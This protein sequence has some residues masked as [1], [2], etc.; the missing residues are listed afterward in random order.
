MSN[1]VEFL[2]ASD[3]LHNHIFIFI[4]PE[5]AGKS[6]QAKMLADAISLPCLSTGDMLRHFAHHDQGHL[7]D[8]CRKM[9]AENGYLDAGL[10]NQIVAETVK[11]EQYQ[12]GVIFD[13]SLRTYDE[14]VHFDDAM[15]QAGLHF[16]ITVFYINISQ[17]ESIARLLQARKRED[18]TIEGIMTR[19]GHFHDRLEERLAII[20][21]RYELIE[22]DGM[23]TIEQVHE[24]VMKLIGV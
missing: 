24:E 8:A 7:G 5:G 20:K 19:L 18:D 21:Q 15:A 13:G 1:P 6:T 12:R 9:F 23:Q 2:M 14:T 10:I 22:I 16:P 11:N 4:G 3:L 17:E